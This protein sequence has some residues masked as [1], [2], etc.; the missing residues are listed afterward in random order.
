MPEL[1]VNT[2]SVLNTANALKTINNQIDS[3]ISSVE[4]EMSKLN[5]SWDGPAASAAMNKYKELKSQMCKERY[6]V[7]DDYMHFLLQLVGEGYEQTE[8]ANTSL[9]SMFKE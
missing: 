1:R 8:T 6:N 2:Q 3:G 5:M 7:I 4:N 9:A